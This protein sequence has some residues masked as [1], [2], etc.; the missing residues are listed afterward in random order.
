MA[1]FRSIPIHTVRRLIFSPPFPIAAA[2]DRLVIFINFQTITFPWTHDVQCRLI[3]PTVT[4]LT[5]LFRIRLR[6]PFVRFVFDIVIAHARLRQSSTKQNFLKYVQKSRETGTK[7]TCWD[8]KDR[9]ENRRPERTSDGHVKGRTW[10]QD[11]I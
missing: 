8:E 2:D 7:R 11:R 10:R 5:R 1:R 9:S 4:K 6:R 3:T